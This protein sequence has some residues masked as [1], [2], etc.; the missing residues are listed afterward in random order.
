MPPESGD[1]LDWAVDQVVEFLCHNPKTPWSQSTAAP[2]RPDPA[3]FEDA[4]RSNMITGEVLLYDVDKATLREDLGLKKIGHWSTILMAIRYLQN[5]SQKYQRAKAQRSTPFEHSPSVF[6]PETPKVFSEAPRMIPNDGVNG[7]STRSPKRSTS[8]PPEKS[9]EDSSASSPRLRPQEHYVVDQQGRKRRKLDLGSI[10]QAPVNGSASPKSNDIHQARDNTNDALQ[11]QDKKWYIG[12]NKIAPYELFYPL[13][14]DDDAEDTFVMCSP[15]FPTAQRLFVKKRLHHFYRQEPLDLGSDD[16]SSKLAVMPY[17]H[18]ITEDRRQKYFTLYSSRGGKVTIQQESIE[19]WPQLYQRESPH[20]EN[21]TGALKSSDPF[22]YL[23]QK[24]PV[25]KGDDGA[26]PLYGDSGSEGE[27]DEE[28]WQEIEHEQQEPMQWKQER[29][30][31]TEIDSIIA[32]CI[33]DF[34]NKWSK[35]HQ[36]KEERKARKLWLT[37]RKNK[38]TNQQ[39]KTISRDL[40][41]LDNRLRKIQAAIRGSEYTT[42]SELQM[43]CQSMEQT[44]FNIQAQKWR[45]SV[46]ERPDCPPKVLAAPKPPPAPKP[47]PNTDGEESLHSESDV[48]SDGSLDDFII[49]DLGTDSIIEEQILPDSSSKKAQEMQE[50]QKTFLQVS[51]SPSSDSDAVISPSGIRRKFRKKRAAFQGKE[52]T[53]DSS[54]IPLSGGSPVRRDASP[55]PSNVTGA[56]EYIDLT[57]DSPPPEVDDDLRIE[58]PPL[59]PSVPK[60]LHQTE[61]KVKTERHISISPQ[62]GLGPSVFVEIR[63]KKHMKDDKAR[64]KKSTSIDFGAITRTP[65]DV[66]EERRDRR[67]LLAK[68]VRSLPDKER[69]CLAKKIPDFLSPLLWKYVI[70]ALKAMANRHHEIRGVDESDQELARRTASLYISWVNCKH[71]ADEGMPKRDLTKAREDSQGFMPFQKELSRCLVEHD[72][73]LQSQSATESEEVPSE[74]DDLRPSSSTPHKKRKREVKESQEVKRNHESAQLRVAVQDEQRRR[75]ERKM[76]SMGLSNSD[77]TR[78]AVSFG[79]PII[80]LHPHIG[81]RVK[82]HQLN[83]IQF[84]WRELIEDEKRQGCVLAHTMG[85]GKTMQV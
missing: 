71:Y 15:N 73:W 6:F 19:K 9:V 62:P 54:V 14:L 48:E 81:R 32:K 16:G 20:S 8:P 84:M 41:L 70:K 56:F 63:N 4:L 65:W 59:N 13:T 77:P 1:P 85:L 61:K 60:V 17:K 21:S 28:T 58:T 57:M 75:L 22:S 39:I 52:R 35:D 51:S 2:P 24:Y 78:Q 38:S 47:K 53:P 34:E 44:V 80:Y 55:S 50:A 23:I 25:Q 36:P 33:N 79:S 27:Y 46:L 43:Q 66:L 37:A 29:L 10:T 68:L 31:S 26:Y 3:T 74:D 76:E 72:K 12:P 83:G 69:K 42:V 67:R 40:S 7:G 30:S 82:Q 64:D 5:I 45:V 11:A 49:D 18:S